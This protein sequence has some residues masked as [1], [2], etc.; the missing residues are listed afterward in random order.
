[1][2]I[3]DVYDYLAN[4]GTGRVRPVEGTYTRDGMRVTVRESHRYDEEEPHVDNAAGVPGKRT[5]RVA[6]SSR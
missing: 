3:V 6:A 4:L 2:L 5:G 1:M